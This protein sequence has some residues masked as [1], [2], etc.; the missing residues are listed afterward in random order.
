[1]ARKTSSSSQPAR[2]DIRTDYAL[3]MVA[4]GAAVL[5]LIYLILI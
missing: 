5:A 4:T 3:I 2:S 1:M